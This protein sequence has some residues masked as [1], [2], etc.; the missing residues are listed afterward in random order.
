MNTLKTILSGLAVG[1]A[2]TIPGVSG[3]TMMVSMGIYDT[4]NL[5]RPDNGGQ[6]RLLRTEEKSPAAPEIRH[7]SLRRGTSHSK[8]DNFPADYPGGSSAE[9]PVSRGGRGRDSHDFPQG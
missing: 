7:R 2:M 9:V 6:P 1:G 3:G 5:R 4:R 8:A